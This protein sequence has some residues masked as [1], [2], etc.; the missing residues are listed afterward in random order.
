MTISK[1]THVMILRKHLAIMLI[2]TVRYSLGRATYMVGVTCDMVREYAH[3]IPRAS[4]QVLL[5]DIATEID[6]HERDGRILGHDMDHR[7][8]KRLLEHIRV[9]E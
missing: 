3:K 1:G 5:R 6:R 8:W 4:L 2:S 9:H 7:E